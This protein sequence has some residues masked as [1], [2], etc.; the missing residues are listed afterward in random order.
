MEITALSTASLT[1]QRLHGLRPGR[2]RAT[3]GCTSAVPATKL[4]VRLQLSDG[5]CSEQ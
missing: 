5:I 1:G 4:Q 3:S 2:R